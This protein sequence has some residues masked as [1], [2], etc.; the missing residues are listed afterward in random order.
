MKALLVEDNALIR[1][2]AGAMLEKLGYDA[3]YA[4]DGAQAVEKC[5]G[6][7]YDVVLMDM[8]MPVMDGDEAGKRI[9]G[10]PS[11]HGEVPIIAVTATD[12][13]DERAKTAESGMNAFLMKPFTQE[14]LAEALAA[15]TRDGDA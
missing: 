4:E 14:T 5:A 6:T 3:E 2:V 11:P 8:H 9:R 7:L 13:E 10:L 12:N 1:R 15:L